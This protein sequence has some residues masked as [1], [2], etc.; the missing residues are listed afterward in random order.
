MTFDVR[1][2]APNEDSALRLVSAEINFNIASPFT[3]KLD[4]LA[5]GDSVVMAYADVLTVFNAGTTNVLELGDATTANKFLAAADVTEGSLGVTPAG[6]KGP[7]TAE[8]AAGVLNAKFTQTGGAA[9]TGKA[10]VYA[11]I[12]NKPA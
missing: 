10:R 8:V 7:F 2:S 5:I 1:S 6:G 12:A 11:L 4:D 3:V 9:T